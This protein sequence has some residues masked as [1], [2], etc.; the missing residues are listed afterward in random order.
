MSALGSLQRAF[1][2]HVLRPTRAMERRV[3]STRRASA[4]MRLAI[5]SNAY[6]ER[7]IE[8]LGIEFEGLQALAGDAAFRRLA[9][10]F[11]AAHPSRRPNL[12]WY[13][14]RLAGFLARAPRWRARPVLAEMAAFEWA[15]GLAFDAPDAPPLTVEALASVPPEDWPAMT[16]R[17]HPAV[18]RLALRSNAPRIWRAAHDR[19]ALPRPARSAQPARWLI[20][21][22]GLLPY[23]R[24]LPEAEARALDL[25]ARGRSF[26]AICAGLRRHLPAAEVAQAAARM[27][28]GWVEEGV[29]RG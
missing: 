27:L 11:I 17:L 12:R 18:H 13:G 2:R 28:K 22:K 15:L 5:Y 4:G 6:R 9:L 3:V 20:W 14:A 10:G 29:L 19:Q 26:E 25:L 8:A 1:Q 16:F 24:R 23:Y 7:L 21:R